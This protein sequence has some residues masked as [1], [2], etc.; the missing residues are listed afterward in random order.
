MSVATTAVAE[1]TPGF[2]HDRSE[3]RIPD[4]VDPRMLT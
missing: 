1:C 4:Y 2:A 3:A